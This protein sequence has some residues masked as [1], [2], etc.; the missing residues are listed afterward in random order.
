MEFEYDKK[1]IPLKLPELDSNILN[2]LTLLETVDIPVLKAL[3][4][5]SCDEITP[6]KGAIQS[7]LDS[8]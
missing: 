5:S 7:Y 8:Q 4:T 2:G 6:Y 3:S 1:W